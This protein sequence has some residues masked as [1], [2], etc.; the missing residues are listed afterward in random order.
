MTD[1]AAS[2]AAGPSISSTFGASQVPA[3]RADLMRPAPLTRAQRRPRMSDR[4]RCGTLR[5][6]TVRG[7]AAASMGRS[8]TARSAADS[9]GPGL[10]ADTQRD[11]ERADP[12]LAGGQRRADGARVQ[13]RAADVDAVVDAGEHEVGLGPD[14][15]ERAGDHR[16]RGGGV[17]PVRLDALGALDVG[18]LVGDGRVV[19]DRAHRGAGAAVVGAR[20]H[21]DD[22]VG[23]R[24]PRRSRPPGP[25][26]APPAPGR[27]PRR[28]W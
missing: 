11:G 5:F 20:R 18:A 2:A 27:P 6:S 12:E 15:P 9:H 26:S 1:R 23:D 13:H 7:G 25:S 21:H 28:R 8:A 17:E 19:G 16:E 14:G 10:V 3:P 24:R 4:G 22:L